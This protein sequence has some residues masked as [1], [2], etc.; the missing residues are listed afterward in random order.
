[1]KRQ[2]RSREERAFQKGYQS[3]ITGKPKESCP[4]DQLHQRQAWLTGW[5]EGRT[6]SWDGYTGVSGIHKQQQL[7]YS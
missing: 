3:G 7:H 4:H 5:R 1:M 2:K 6:D